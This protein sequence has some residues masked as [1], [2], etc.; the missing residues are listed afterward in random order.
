ME[1][2]QSLI[3]TAQEVAEYLRLDVATVYKLAQA[4]MIPGTKIGRSWR[5]KRELIDACLQEEDGVTESPMRA[6]FEGE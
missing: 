4:G 1:S 3:M 5:F 2:K 6:P